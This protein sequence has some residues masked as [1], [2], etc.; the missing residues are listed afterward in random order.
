MKQ[1][2]K[3]F[4]QLS[5]LNL[6]SSSQSTGSSF[7]I[8]CLQVIASDIGCDSVRKKKE[9]FFCDKNHFTTKIIANVYTVATYVLN[10]K[11][12]HKIMESWKQNANISTSQDKW[13]I[14]S[15]CSKFCTLYLLGWKLVEARAGF[16]VEMKNN[17]H[18]ALGS[19][20]ITVKYVRFHSIDA[21]RL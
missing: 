8:L 7:R 2:W 18:T 13:V 15:C 21:S 10:K 6:L 11:H 4:R 1:Y 20:N 16:N 12:I 19:W 9:F 5:P 3:K 17:I 14:A